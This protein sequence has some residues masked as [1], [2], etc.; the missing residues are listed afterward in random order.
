MKQPEVPA[1]LAIVGRK[2]RRGAARSETMTRATAARR[3]GRLDLWRARL[4]S[5]DVWPGCLWASRPGKL[6]WGR[7]TRSAMDHGGPRSYG[8]VLA[9]GRSVGAKGLRGRGFG[10]DGV[11]LQVEVHPLFAALGGRIT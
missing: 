1:R 2:L 4:G 8:R 9:G 6:A 3:E 11:W 5:A 10:F 7:R